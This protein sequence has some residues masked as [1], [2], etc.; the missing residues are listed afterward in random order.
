NEGY[1]TDADNILPNSIRLGHDPNYKCRY[2]LIKVCN[3]EEYTF[4]IKF[5]YNAVGVITFDEKGNKIALYGSKNSLELTSPFVIDE[6][7]AFILVTSFAD[8]SDNGKIKWGITL[9]DN[10][11]LKDI[12]YYELLSE[13]ITNDLFCGDIKYDMQFTVRDRPYGI[14]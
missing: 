11:I 12:D 8:H 9:N 2:T 10:D 14:P 13:A 7:T 3:G 1:V 4:D 6:N 5:G